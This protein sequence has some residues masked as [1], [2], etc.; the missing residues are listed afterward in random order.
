MVLGRLSSDGMRRLFLVLLLTTTG[1]AGPHSNGA[2]WSLQNAQQ[3]I[4]LYA[5]GDA[6]RQAQAQAYEL[7]L[8]DQT[9]ASERDRLQVV[10]QTCPGPRQAFDLSRADAARDAARVQAQTD[11]TRLTQLGQ[12]SLADWYIRRAEATGDAQFCHMAKD[13][14]NGTTQGTSNAQDLL[15][16]IPAATVSRDPRRTPPDLARD[17]ALESLSTYALGA[18]DSLTAAAPLPQYL[19]LVYGGSLQP[20][21]DPVLDQE[22]AAAAVDRAAPAF[23]EWEPDALYAA[24]RGGHQ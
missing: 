3:E 12:V 18:I 1:C 8:A 19:A 14:L 24:L 4:A 17:P 15:A 5:L 23:P 2:L 6:Q 22:A 7:S 21:Q 9:L 16:Q 13:A 20:P 11:N 10:M